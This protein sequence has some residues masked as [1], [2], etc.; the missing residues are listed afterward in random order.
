MEAFTGTEELHSEAEG[1]DV[2]VERYGEE[3][4]PDG[5]LLKNVWGFHQIFAQAFI[6]SPDP[7]KLL[8]KRLTHFLARDKWSTL[9]HIFVIDKKKQFYNIDTWAQCYKTF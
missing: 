5:A 8:Y 7:L 1:N 2:F 4:E 9:F 6:R 3:Q